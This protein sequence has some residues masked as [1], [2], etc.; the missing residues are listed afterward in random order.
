MNNEIKIR[1]ELLR[2]AI[3]KYDYEYY[4]NANSIISDREYDELFKELEELENKY[5]EYFDSNSPTQR[6]GGKPL[7]EF[8]SVTHEIPMLSLGNTYS[9]EDLEDFDARIF[10]LLGHRNYSYSCELKFDGVAISLIY[11]SGALKLGVTRGDGF[12]GDDITQNIK[13]IRSV[14]LRVNEVIYKDILL[15]DFEVRGEVFMKI[16]D[17]N[18]INEEREKQGE[19]LYANPRNTAAG[20]LKLLD[21]KIVAQRNLQIYTYFLRSNS[22]KL[23]SHQENIKLLK[24]LGFPV[25]EAQKICNNLEEVFDFINEWNEKRNSLPFQID[26]IVIKVNSLALQEELGFVARSPRWAIAYKFEAENAETKLLDIK[27]QIGRTGVVTP[28]AVLE[29]VLLAGS[30]ISRATLHN[31]D[32]IKE[33]DIRIGD[34]VVI[35]KGGDVI[36]KVVKVVLENRPENVIEFQFPEFTETGARIYRPDGEVNYY[37]DD[38]NNPILLKRK[39][40]HFVSRNAL[41]IEGFGEKV[42]DQLVD[43]KIVNDSSD[44][45]TLHEKKDELL[46]LERW[47]EKSVDNLL[48]AIEVSKNQSFERVLFGLGIRFIGQGGAKLLSEHFKNIDALAAATKEDLIAVYEIGDKMADSI[49]AYFSDENNQNIIDKL[50]SFGLNFQA[51]E[52]EIHEHSALLAG[53]TFV[54]TGE[55]EKMTRAEAAKLIENFGGKETKSVSKKTDFVVV[56]NNPGSKYDKAV[57][58]NV[59]IFDENEFIKFVSDLK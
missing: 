12:T 28:V 7:D 47:G 24:Q 4:V 30:T 32:Y 19:N 45:Y 11:E 10:K 43:L 2:N 37:T 20:S 13:T 18:K 15:Q 6:V 49:I 14:P 16:E 41:D 35:E 26:G 39:I 55:L 31:I 5:P 53:K 52:K 34:T 8:A 42:I 48:N 40:E 33:R 50:K 46:K 1:I 3:N 22:V 54:F 36:P 38:D 23:E 25:F 44:I 59:T 29:P 58:L 27:L 9:R 17:F 56:G 21:S 57:K 51:E